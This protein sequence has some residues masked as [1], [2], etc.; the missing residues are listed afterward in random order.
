[1]TANPY[2]GNSSLAPEVKDRVLST[3]AQTLALFEDGRLDEV[4]AG[5]DLLLEM[6]DRFEPARKLRQ[7]AKDPAAAVDLS[8][9]Y[10]LRDSM[11]SGGSQEASANHDAL[12]LE[13]VEQLNAG[14][15]AAAV[16]ICNTILSTDPSHEEAQAIGG[17]ANE[18]LEADPF[19]RQFIQEADTALARGDTAAAEGLIEKARSLDPMHPEIAALSSRIAAAG[20]APAPEAPSSGFD[21]GGGS[22]PF[23]GAFGEQPAS[24]PA[25]EG[26][27]GFDGTPDP[28]PESP[29]EP[30]PSSFDFGINDGGAEQVATP[31]TPVTPSPSGEAS[32]FGFTLEEEPQQA[33]P[34]DAGGSSPAPPEMV[35][36]EAQTFDFSTGDVEVSEDD[37]QK[38]ANYLGEGDELFEAGEYQGAIDSWS[39]IFLIDVTNEQASERIEKAKERKR[40]VDQKLDDLVTT[41]VAAY[42]RGDYHTARETFEEVLAQDPDNFRAGEYLEKLSDHEAATAGGPEEVVIPPPPPAPRLEEPEGDLYEGDMYEGDVPTPPPP[43]A[44]ARPKKTDGTRPATAKKS[45]KGLIIAAVVVVLLAVGGWFAWSTLK[46]GDDRLQSNSSITQGKINRAN[47]LAENGDF[48]QAISILSDIPAGDPMRE[49]ALQLIAQFRQQQAAA[50][51]MVGGRPMAEVREELLVSARESFAS[52]DYMAAKSAFEEAAKLKALEGADREM[53]DAAS[54]QVSKLD[55]ATS[56]FAQGSYREAIQELE[57]ILEAEPDNLNAHEMLANAHFNLGVAALKN[58][59]TG[60][61]IAEFDSVLQH[62]PEDTMARRSLEIAQL[63]QDKPKDLMYEIFVK[64]LPQR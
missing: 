1:M 16:S 46:G 19:V 15:Y 3:F 5:C 40:N 63:Y 41:G 24:P 6:D 58:R 2:P 60:D 29:A 56:L 21:F 13:A 7:K 47:L 61:A 8:D 31:D 36:G 23:A 32:S 49:E 30:E 33:E 27:F 28:E 45:P 22:S 48:A 4:V 34:S 54:R 59:N 14:N 25:D 9:L 43:A 17:Q 12:I 37:Q 64:Y 53:Y 39:K 62:N 20:T 11:A 44:T 42:D 35:P 18:R 10:S 55:T 51:G 50:G 57:T 52:E 38:I 26:G